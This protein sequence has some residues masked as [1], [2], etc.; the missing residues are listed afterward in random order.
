MSQQ[1]VINYL[2]FRD[3]GVGIGGWGR[4]SYVHA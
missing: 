4:I 1:Y 2:Y 3:T